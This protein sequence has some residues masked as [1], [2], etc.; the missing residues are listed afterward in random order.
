MGKVEKKSSM[1][2]L[3]NDNSNDIENMIKEEAENDYDN[4]INLPDKKKKMTGSMLKA[5][6]KSNMSV[7]A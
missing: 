6:M 4:Y 5:K 1:S 7:S 3:V 2:S